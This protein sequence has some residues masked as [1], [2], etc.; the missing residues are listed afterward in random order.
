M[1]QTLHF[2]PQEKQQRERPLPPD[3]PPRPSLT[4]SLIP[5]AYQSKTVRHGPNC[6]RETI[7][8][9][10]ARMAAT[11]G[12]HHGNGG[13]NLQERRTRQLRVGGDQGRVSWARPGTSSQHGRRREFR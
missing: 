12:T 3:L 4:L 5:E 7:A 13:G 10:A 11:G 1:C 6:S 8:N 9:P 2:A